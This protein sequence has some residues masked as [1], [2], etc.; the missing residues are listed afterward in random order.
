MLDTTD[1]YDGMRRK[2]VYDEFSTVLLEARSRDQVHHDSN[3]PLKRQGRKEI[4][5]K[6]AFWQPRQYIDP[7]MPPRIQVSGEKAS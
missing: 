2:K 6:H 7:G 5:H 3:M 1:L 4:Q